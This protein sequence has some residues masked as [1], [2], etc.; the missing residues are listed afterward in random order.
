M[1][2]AAATIVLFGL[3]ANLTLLGAHWWL[4]LL[5]K[6]DPAAPESYVWGTVLGIVA[7]FVTWLAFWWAFRG[8]SI[9]PGTVIL[10]FPVMTAMAGL[11]T[12]LAYAIDRYHARH[13][14]SALRTARRDRLATSLDGDGDA[15]RAAA[16][17]LLDAESDWDR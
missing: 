6:R 1:L 8:P 16:R 9:H 13:V 10:A 7:P 3:L 2:F 11:G 5:L 15:L 17:E 12:L 4:P 14:G